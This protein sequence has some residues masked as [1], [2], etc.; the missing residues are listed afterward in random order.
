MYIN[1]EASMSFIINENFNTKSTL[2]A[3]LQDGTRFVFSQGRFDRWCIFHVRKNKAHAVRDEEVFMVMSHYAS[4]HTRFLLYRDFLS[5]F[6]EV[7]NHVNYDLVEK[8]VSISKAYPRPQE[9]QFILLFLYAGMIAEEN[10]EKAILKK[11]I[12][13]F[14]VHQVLIEGMSPTVAA[15]YSRGKRWRELE[16]EC[17]VRGFYADYDILKL[18]A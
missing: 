15:N 16:L 6:N 10:K 18:S 3:H 14:G 4:G 12:K 8:I 17:Q 1:L 11:F 2:I 7:T 5:I 9:V 13:R